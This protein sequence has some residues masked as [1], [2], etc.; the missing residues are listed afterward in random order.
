MQ[1]PA[2]FDDSPKATD[3]VGFVVTFPDFDWGVTQGDTEGEA[4][5][6]AQDALLLMIQEHIRTGQPVPRP[7]R[8]RGKKYRM[9]ELPAMESAKIELYNAFRDSGITKAEFARRLAIPKT[10]VDR[11]FDF[12]NHTRL[13]QLEAAFRALGKHVS[14]QIRDAA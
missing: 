4:S 6:M 1:Y 12:R 9:I 5:E 2:F 14:I 11:L 10:T 7:G 8:P 3:G 13:D